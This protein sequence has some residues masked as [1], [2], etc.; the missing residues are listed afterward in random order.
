MN[1][2]WIP[3]EDNMERDNLFT[4]DELES[5]DRNNE[6][7]SIINKRRR[8]KKRRLSSSSERE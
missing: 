6:E 3:T 2:T 7:D 1:R 8:Q 4:A 5:P